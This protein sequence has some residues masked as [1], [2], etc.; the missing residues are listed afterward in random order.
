MI[1]T[2]IHLSLRVIL[3]EVLDID[4]VSQFDLWLNRCVSGFTVGFGFKNIFVW[5]ELE[6][7]WVPWEARWYN[8]PIDMRKI[9]HHEFVVNDCQ[10]EAG[11]NILEEVSCFIPHP[12]LVVIMLDILLEVALNSWPMMEVR[13]SNGF[14]ILAAKNKILSQISFRLCKMKGHLSVALHTL[15]DFFLLWWWLNWVHVAVNDLELVLNIGVKRQRKTSWK[16]RL[17]EGSTKSI[18]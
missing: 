13:C 1:D 8:I 7:L 4:V 12:K 16:E 11:S 18:E 2:F 5:A 14:I 17:S 3:S 9:C 10:L 6:P 15:L